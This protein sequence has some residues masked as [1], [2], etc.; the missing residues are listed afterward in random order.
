MEGWKGGGFGV[1]LEVVGVKGECWFVIGDIGD[2]Y[3]NGNYGVGVVDLGIG[4]GGCW[5]VRWEGVVIEGGYE[6][7]FYVYWCWGGVIFWIIVVVDCCVDVVVYGG[8]WWF[9]CEFFIGDLDDGGRFVRGEVVGC[10]YVFLGLFCI[11]WMFILFYELFWWLKIKK[12]E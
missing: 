6:I 9:L 5:W 11:C 7:F 10:L 2:C 8:M 4:K 1:V 12:K 3:G